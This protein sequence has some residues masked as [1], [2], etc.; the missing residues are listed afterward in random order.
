MAK[1]TEKQRKFVLYYEGDGQTAAIK[2]GYA[3][4]SARI[5][6]SKLLTQPNIQKALAKRNE[7]NEVPT[8]ASL[9]ERKEILTAIAKGEDDKT[10][11]KAIDVLNKM[12]AVYVQ[13][14]ELKNWKDKSERAQ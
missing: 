2:A 11:V 5:S 4:N 12:D 6:A 14:V 3:P 9:I 8:I 10:K 1:L 13:K 7:V